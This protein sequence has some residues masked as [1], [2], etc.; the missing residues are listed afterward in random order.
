MAKLEKIKPIL[1]AIRFF[2]ITY[3]SSES[4]QFDLIIPFC[5]APLTTQLFSQDSIQY[6]AGFLLSLNADMLPDRLL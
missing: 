5:R 4:N 2:L 1:V 6:C 3:L